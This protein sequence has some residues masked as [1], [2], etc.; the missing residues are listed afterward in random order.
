[1]LTAPVAAE[2]EVPALGPTPI[3]QLAEPDLFA[4]LIRPVIRTAARDYI[5]VGSTVDAGPTGK[6][7]HTMQ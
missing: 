5:A 6:F 2:V 3:G 7:V 4:Q 1:M